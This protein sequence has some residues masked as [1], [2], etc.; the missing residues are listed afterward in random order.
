MV[1]ELGVPSS[2]SFHACAHSALSDVRGFSVYLAV[3]KPSKLFSDQLAS[4]L[5]LHVVSLLLCL[6]A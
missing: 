5:K 3:T 6:A 2:T 4:P 1:W